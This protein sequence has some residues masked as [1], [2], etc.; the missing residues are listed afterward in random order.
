MTPL[1]VLAAHQ[2]GTYGV[3]CECGWQGDEKARAEAQRADHAA[4]VLDALAKAGHEV[5]Q[6]VSIEERWVPVTESGERWAPRSRDRAEEAMRDW[7]VGGVFEQSG[8]PYD[9][10]VRVV[11]ERRVTTDW[12]PVAAAA[13]ETGGK[14]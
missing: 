2:L 3:D 12:E 8:E 7:P 1:E 14:A 10:I 11:H 4:H 13:A 6:A 9:G 5:V